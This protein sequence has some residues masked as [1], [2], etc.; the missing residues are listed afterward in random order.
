MNIRAASRSTV[1]AAPQRWSQRAQLRVLALATA[2]G[3]IGLAA[4][5]SAG[6]L[7]AAR[8]ASSDAAVGLPLGVLVLG[9]A[10]AAMLI[11]RLTMRLGRL[12]SLALGYAI[13]ACGAALVV[14]ALMMTSLPELLVGSA[15]LGAANAAIFFTRYAAAALADAGRRGQALGAVLFATALG[16][17]LGA[18]LLGPSASLAE[19]VRLPR[20][21]GLYLLALCA[22]TLAGLV[23]AAAPRLGLARLGG[24]ADPVSATHGTRF[25]LRS[26]ASGPA[27]SAVAAIAATNFVMVA[28]MAVAPVHLRMAGMTLQLVGVMVAMHVAGMFVP[29][30]VSGWLCDRIGSSIVMTVGLLLL[31]GTGV[32]GAVA[33]SRVG[34]VVPVVLILLGI[35]WNLGVVGASSALAATVPGVLQPQVE[36]LGEVAMGVAAALAAPLAG[37]ILHFAGFAAVWGGGAVVAAVTL[38]L[39]AR[40]NRPQVGRQARASGGRATRERQGV[41]VR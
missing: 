15:L 28:V 36:G 14:T 7:L 3:A 25:A 29:A 17:V 23:L 31:F 27:R 38:V 16:A 39:L 2:I 1:G 12:R 26:V 11:S 9:S 37:L 20:E 6:A 10:A 33:T 18:T 13:G 41:C 19:A 5:G 40:L 4:G 30:P 22:F 24:V 34:G 35:G 21:S 32:A 8:L